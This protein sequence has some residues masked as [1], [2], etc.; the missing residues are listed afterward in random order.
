MANTLAVKTRSNSL[1]PLVPPI[2]AI[3]LSRSPVPPEAPAVTHT[4]TQI[5]PVTPSRSSML[6]PPPGIVADPLIAPSPSTQSLRGLAS[7]SSLEKRVPVPKPVFMG[8]S[9]RPSHVSGTTPALPRLGVSLPAEALEARRRVEAMIPGPE[10]KTEDELLGEWMM[11]RGMISE[12]D[13]ANTESELPTNPWTLTLAM[14]GVRLDHFDD[15]EGAEYWDKTVTIPENPILAAG[16]EWLTRPDDDDFLDGFPIPEWLNPDVDWRLPKLKIN[17]TEG[18][19]WAM[20][21]FRVHRE[22]DP[23][24][25]DTLEYG[26]HVY[27]DHITTTAELLQAARAATDP[28]AA[29]QAETEILLGPRNAAQ[30]RHSERQDLLDRDRLFVALFIAIGAIIG[31]VCIAGIVLFATQRQRCASNFVTLPALQ[32]GLLACW[33]FI[34]GWGIMF[35]T[36]LGEKLAAA[37][38]MYNISAA[39]TLEAYL[40]IA[41]VLALGALSLVEFITVASDAG[42]FCRFESPHLFNFNVF[43]SIFTLYVVLPCHLWAIFKAPRHRSTDPL[44]L[45]PSEAIVS[46]PA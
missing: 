13:L 24:L 19:N 38:V 43:V 42:L 4:E 23:F 8:R 5:Q 44:D 18:V 6:S 30:L 17:L 36:P 10:D 12:N 37:L 1:S 15:T 9:M 32:L 7:T 22:S 41:N 3:P 29:R 31:A 34:P 28:R 45:A 46:L 16:F 40:L 27:E 2:P 20:A 11:Q 35:W 25:D 21:G 26:D 14:A 39:S 33:L